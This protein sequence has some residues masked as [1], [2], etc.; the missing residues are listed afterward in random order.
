MRRIS[1]IGIAIFLAVFAPLSAHS[2]FVGPKVPDEF[3]DTSMLKPPPGSSVAIVVF[4]D[5]GCPGC[6]RAHPIE[7]QAAQQMHVPILRY[8]FPIPAHIWTFKA[9]L[10]ARYLQDKVNP[11]LAE[12]FRTN[13]FATQASIESQDDIQRFTQRWLQQHG[14]PAPFVLDPDGALATK[15]LADYNLGIRLH[16]VQT[17]TVVVVTRNAYQVV[18]GIHDGN[19]DPSRLLA[20]LRAA[21]AQAGSMHGTPSKKHAN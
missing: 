2:Q 3:R 7:L 18:C 10:F 20:I 14:Q 1:A 9:A 8:D 13:V 21:V 12:Q 4:E 5:L 19:N 16:L 17:P 15:V 6:A 11:Q